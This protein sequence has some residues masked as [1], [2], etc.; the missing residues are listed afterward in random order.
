[1]DNNLWDDFLLE[2]FAPG[3]VLGRVDIVCHSCG[4]ITSHQCNDDGSNAYLCPACGVR[5]EV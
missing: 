4:E 2:C 5:N 3:L 1:M